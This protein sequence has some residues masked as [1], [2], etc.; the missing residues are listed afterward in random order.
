M[1]GICAGIC[2]LLLPALLACGRAQEDGNT[3]A[4]TV[5]QPETAQLTQAPVTEEDYRNAISSAS[6]EEKI[7]LYRDFCANYIMSEEEYRDY[8]GL[9]ADAGDSLSARDVLFM[10]YRS[11][12]SEEHGELLAAQSVEMTGENHPEAE[13]VLARLTES[14]EKLGTD[15][16]SADEIRELLASDEWKDTFYID[17]GTFTSHT[18]VSGGRLSASVDSDS[19][20]TKV[21]LTTSDEGFLL[22]VTPAHLSAGRRGN[23]DDS[24]VYRSIGAD[25]VDI[26]SV[27]GYAKEGHYVNQLDLTVDGLLYQGSFDDAGK[28]KEEQP[29]G[30]NGT[31]Y[32]YSD[33]QSRYLYAEGVSPDN[34][35]ATPDALGF[36][37]F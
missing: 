6:G 28:T 20:S 31:V 2:I 34:F 21:L 32:A 14:L 35:V 9:L 37:T 24:Y 5:S 25:G 30:V 12:P 36:E 8:A 11:D 19:L 17:N 7:A 26:V 13:E 10:L 29:E 18:E 27:T 15:D 33:D 23:A 3:P 1:K 16:F 22:H 4:E